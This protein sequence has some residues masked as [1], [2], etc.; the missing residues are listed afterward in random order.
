MATGTSRPR[1][2]PYYFNILA[3]RRS[4]PLSTDV[5]EILVKCFVSILRASLYIHSDKDG[6]FSIHL[7]LLYLRKNSEQ[8][9][10]VIG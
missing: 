8:V 2:G 4:N 5:A 10:L 6:I 1:R 3:I 9:I 7:S